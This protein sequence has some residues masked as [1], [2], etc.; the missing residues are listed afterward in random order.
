M[1]WC[2]RC[3]LMCQYRNSDSG[4]RVIVRTDLRKSVSLLF[5]PQCI[6][7][8]TKYRQKLAINGDPET[9]TANIGWPTAIDPLITTAWNNSVIRAQ[10]L[11]RR[12]CSSYP[13]YSSSPHELKGLSNLFAAIRTKFCNVG[14]IPFDWYP[15]KIFRVRSWRRYSILRDGVA[16]ITSS[17]SPSGC[18]VKRWW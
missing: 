5:N 2:S 15:P 7:T 3:Q 4:S 12:R 6:G 18:K 9:N 10:T 11:A 16:G 14:S 8:P 13:L 1:I 17:R